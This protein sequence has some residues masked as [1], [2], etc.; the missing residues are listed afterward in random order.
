MA[1]VIQFAG[2]AFLMAKK[3]IV[4]PKL[5]EAQYN[6]LRAMADLLT[7]LFA[8]S[9]E[10]L[11]PALRLWAARGLEK[12]AWLVN[13]CAA[14]F[15]VKPRKRAEGKDPSTVTPPTV[16]VGVDGTLSV[17]TAKLVAAQAV[18]RLFG[19]HDTAQACLEAFRHIVSMLNGTRTEGDFTVIQDEN[20]ISVFENDENGAPIGKGTL[21]VPASALPP[22]ETEEAAKSA[23]S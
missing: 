6:L 23:V 9:D 17:K 4:H 16:R 21:I 10:T 15:S 7:A 12:L 20:G 18:L 22:V 2:M 11:Q 19:A 8:R 14:D 5:S 3:A 1:Q 13:D